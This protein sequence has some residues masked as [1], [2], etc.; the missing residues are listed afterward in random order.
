MIRA[1]AGYLMVV[2]ARRRVRV[3]LPLMQDSKIWMEDLVMA[4]IEGGRLCCGWAEPREVTDDAQTLSI[5]N[6][7]A[8][9][10]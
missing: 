2:E 3:E 7:R 1:A 8:A 4:R 9:S 10:S 5:A 6:P